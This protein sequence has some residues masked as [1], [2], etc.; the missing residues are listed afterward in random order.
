MNKYKLVIIVTIVLIVLFVVSGC[1][2]QVNTGAN[3]EPR[4]IQTYGEAEVAAEP[5]L[6]RIGLAIETRSSSAE[7]AVEEN[8]RL[9]NAV[10]EALKGFGLTEDE[11]QTGTY[12]LYSYR[13]WYDERP[14]GEGSITY[15]AV[16]EVIVHTNRVEEVGEMIDLAVRAGANN[17]NFIN[18]ELENPQELQLQA[19]Q[20]A[21]NQAEMKADAIAES[22]GEKISGL[23]RIREE[24]TD[25][26]PYMVRQEMAE[27]MAMEA[28][29]PIAPGEVTVKAAVTAEFDF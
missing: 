2:T 20:A 1:G 12:Q 18:F 6:V 23:Y 7:Q 11:I 19:L 9:A 27:D 13:E 24:R 29:T 3:G 16:N 25:Y 15:Q 10:L 28:P 21:T 22:A 8:A 26:M 5:D 4:L 14:A 17:I